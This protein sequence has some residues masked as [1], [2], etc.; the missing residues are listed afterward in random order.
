MVNKVVNIVDYNNTLT[1]FK[2]IDGLTPDKVKRKYI[3]LLNA[4]VDNAI[5]GEDYYGLVWYSGNWIAGEWEDGSWHS[6]IWFDGEWKNGNFYSYRYDTKQLLL[7]KKRILEK[8]NP[9][10]S[11]FRNGIWRRGN[12]YNGYFGSENYNETWDVLAGS[13]NKPSVEIVYYK[14]R[15]ESGNF[16]NGVFRNSTWYDGMFHNGIFYNS[17]WLRGTFINGTFQGHDWWSGNFTGGDFILG[18]WWS[19]KFNQSNPTIK[20]RFGSFPLSKNLAD[21][22]VVWH[23]GEFI[24]GEFHSGLNI[25]DGITQPSNDHTRTVWKDGVWYNGV[26]YGGTHEQGVFNNGFWFEGYWLD[27]IFNNG[28]WL[29]GHWSDGTTNGG[30]FAYGI[31]LTGEFKGGQFGYEPPRN[32]LE[33]QLNS[34]SMLNLYPKYLGFIPSVSTD[35]VTGIT[36]DSAECSGTVVSDGEQSVTSRGICWSTEYYPTLSDDYLVS[37]NGVGGFWCYI[38]GL[39]DGTIYY[40]RAFATNASGTVYG[41]QVEFT[42]LFLP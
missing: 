25:V 40:V 21:S 37:G 4:I 20:S 15:W 29:N 24:N 8:D 6:G 31:F 18:N 22:V 3:W 2:L 19:G 38:T 11:Q 32:L 1:N 35:P 5:I 23:D 27:G 12:F 39:K 41:N 30:F 28:Y 7:R 42:T 16:Y 14:N 10:H 33:K 26:W 17:Q 34:Q 13:S 9:V 36:Y